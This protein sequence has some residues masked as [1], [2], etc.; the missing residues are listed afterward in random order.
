LY[1][2]YVEKTLHD[3]LPLDPLKSIVHLQLTPF[4]AAESKVVP[5]HY[6]MKIYGGVEVQLQL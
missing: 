3:R 4:D 2:K 1:D 5:V 6:A